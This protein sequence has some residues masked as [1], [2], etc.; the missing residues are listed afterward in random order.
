MTPRCG[1]RIGERALVSSSRSSVGRVRR[2]WS[3]RFRKNWRYDRYRF[4]GF[5]YYVAYLVSG[6]VIVV[7]AVAHERRHPRYWSDRAGS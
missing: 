4:R 6:E 5:P 1:T 2:R 3:G 7:L